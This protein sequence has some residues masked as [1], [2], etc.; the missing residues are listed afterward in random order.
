MSDSICVSV[1][2]VRRAAV[3][4]NGR[5]AGGKS[6]AE[7]TGAMSYTQMIVRERYR[8]KRYLGSA[9]WGE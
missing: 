5:D 8:S 4:K 9:T 3:E 2:T 7:N 1:F 6:T